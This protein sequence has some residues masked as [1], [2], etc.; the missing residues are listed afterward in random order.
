VTFIIGQR[1]S[2]AVARDLQQALRVERPDVH[3]G[4]RFGLHARE[5]LAVRAEGEP[6]AGLRGA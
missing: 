4:H 5:E 3:E 1:A 2:D 6:Y